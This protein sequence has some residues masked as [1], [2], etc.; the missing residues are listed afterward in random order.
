MHQALVDQLVEDGMIRSAALEVA[1]RTVPRHLFL[2]GEPLDRVYHDKPIVTKRRE[3][4]VPISSSSQPA[5]MAIMLEQLDVRPGHRIL[6]IGAGTGYNAALLARLAGSDGL[7]VSIDIDE[8]II[9]NAT[10]HLAAAAVPES[11]RVELIQA[12]GGHGWPA[13]RPYDRIILT[14]GAW[15]IAPAW[16]DQLAPTGRLLIPLWLRGAQRTVAFERDGDHLK[17]VSV[18]NCAFMRLRGAFAGPEGF[19]ALGPRENGLTLSLDDQT[20]VDPGTINALL[21]SPGR[22]QPVGIAVPR[23]R[24]AWSGLSLWLALHE[25]G[26]CLV[27][28]EGDAPVIPIVMH[29]W[30]A[31]LGLVEPDAIVLLAPADTSQPDQPVRLVARPYGPRHDLAER[32]ANQV[33]AWDRAGRPDDAGLQIDAY[34]IDQPVS[35]RPG[36]TTIAKRWHR[37]VITWRARSSVP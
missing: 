30:S 3:D 26:F 12:D 18:S 19:V 34:P 36:A 13:G 24:E 9:A 31:T 37:F 25:T 21:A 16:V 4:G 20:S 5:A 11:G 1:F 10:E 35:A 14:V 33:I 6:E 29:E 17:S 8:D 15:D 32:L 22:D 2:P 27:H 23:G 28:T 7:V